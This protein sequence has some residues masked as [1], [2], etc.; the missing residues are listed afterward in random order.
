MGFTSYS[1]V[2][3]PAEYIDPIDLNIYAQGQAR[4]Q[5]RAEQNLQL[6]QNQVDNILSIP[7]YGKD[8]E[9]LQE[10]AQGLKQRLSSFNLSNLNNLGTFSKI[11]DTINH[12]SNDPDVLAIAERGYNYKNMLDEKKEF[13]KRGKT[14]VNRGLNNLNNYYQSGTYLREVP[15]G[16]D[17]Y[18]APESGKYMEEVKKSVRPDKKQVQNADGTYQM[19]EYY[20]PKK[21]KEAFTSLLSQDPNWQ[22]YQRDSFE[23]AYSNVDM[24]TKAKEDYTALIQTNLINLQKLDEIINN[25]KL[26]NAQK[27]VYLDYADSLKSEIDRANQVL[28]NPYS[29]EAYKRELFQKQ[30]DSEINKMVDA[31]QFHSEGESKMNEAVKLNLQFAHD[32]EMIKRQEQKEKNVLVY[33]EEQKAKLKTE[34]AKSKIDKVRQEALQRAIDKGFDISDPSQPDGYISNEDLDKLDLSKNNTGKNIPHT[35]GAGELQEYY[36][37]PDKKQELRKLFKS[38]GLTDPN[39]IEQLEW[40]EDANAY[41]IKTNGWLSFEHDAYISQEE[42]DKIL[43]PN[44]TKESKQKEYKGLDSNGDPIFE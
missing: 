15:F 11:K 36:E 33:K 5:Q 10:I 27:S 20:E 6:I 8:K 4:N 37:D 23:E 29:G 24:N 7:A 18:A 19:V 44:S 13:E 21:L 35:I 12:V 3:A 2:V 39:D 9:K 42:F 41:K 30:I 16:N 17:G 38:K 1:Q 14:Y 34:L 40:D 28:N 43:K 32:Y 25:P 31:L 22:K 26:S